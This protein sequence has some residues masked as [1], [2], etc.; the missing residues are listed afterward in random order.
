MDIVI[1][2]AV[3]QTRI[4]VYT[5]IFAVVGIM[6]RPVFQ[7]IGYP[8]PALIMTI[9]RM[10]ILNVPSILI[11]VYVFDL[12]M[13]GVWFGMIVGNLTSA[14]ISYLRVKSWFVKLKT[15]EIK[16]IKT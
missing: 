3:T 10:L 2:Y 16:V 8:M 12:K 13:Y 9:L 11:L 14:V 4:V 7:A 15:G 6:E 5:Y 1:N